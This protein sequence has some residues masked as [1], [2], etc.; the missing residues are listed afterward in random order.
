MSFAKYHF[1]E[2][3]ENIQHQRNKINILSN[4]YRLKFFRTKCVV[5]SGAGG[6][7]RHHIY[8]SKWNEKKELTENRPKRHK[9]FL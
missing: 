2:N 4:P 7:G 3:R 5:R 6:E 8:N 9:K 1:S